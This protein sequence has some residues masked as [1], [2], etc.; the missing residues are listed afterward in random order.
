MSNVRSVG[1]GLRNKMYKKVVAPVAM[2][3]AE[4]WDVMVQKRNKCNALEVRYL[5]SVFGVTRMGGEAVE[6]WR[7]RV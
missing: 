7:G 4:R 5:R 6:E 1:S 2:F 3:G